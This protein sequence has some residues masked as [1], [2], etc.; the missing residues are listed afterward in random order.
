MAERVLPNEAAIERQDDDGDALL[1]AAAGRS[2]R[3]GL[4][5]PHVPPEAGGTGTAS[6]TTRT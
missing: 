2:A 4:W 5:A 6:S 3:A 1:A